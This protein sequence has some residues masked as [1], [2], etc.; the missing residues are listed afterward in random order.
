MSII[1]NKAAVRRALEAWFIAARSGQTM[2]AQETAKLSSLEAAA[3]SSDFF[4]DALCADED[5]QQYVEAD[6]ADAVVELFAGQDIVA[7]EKVV[8]AADGKVMPAD[9]SPPSNPTSDD[10][11]G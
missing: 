3:N 9:P 6:K 2:S 7:G 10:L 5:V 4:Y 1:V 11:F 8:I